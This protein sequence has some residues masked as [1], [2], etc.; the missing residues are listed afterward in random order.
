MITHRPWHG[1][2]GLGPRVQGLR[3]Q[4]CGRLVCKR[5]LLLQGLDLSVRPIKQMRWVLPQ[6]FQI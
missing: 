1:F 4:V 2:G 6:Q 5:G 3:K